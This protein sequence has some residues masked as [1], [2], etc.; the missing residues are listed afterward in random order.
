MTNLNLL[1]LDD[2]RNIEDVTWIKYPPFS[3][4]II[5]RTFEDFKT[6]A[7]K[8]LS[9][10]PLSEILFSFDHDIQDFSD[11]VEYTGYTC[12]K[13]LVDLLIDSFEYFNTTG[14]INYIVHSMN[15][16]GKKNIE[17]YV[18]SANLWKIK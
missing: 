5:V 18:N 12:V 15:P 10:H 1:F 11:D 8:L 13:W 17:S 6:E 16:I 14:T 7:Y 2:E 4:I 9:V 3:N